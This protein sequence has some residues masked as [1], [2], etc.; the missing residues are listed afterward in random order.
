MIFISIK[1]T[2]NKIILKNLFKL[3]LDKIDPCS[4]ITSY[5]KI[6]EVNPLL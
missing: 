6:D 3:N 2:H 4:S 1:S 5:F